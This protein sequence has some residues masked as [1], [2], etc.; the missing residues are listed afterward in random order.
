MTTSQ[1]ALISEVRVTSTSLYM[2]LKDG[3]V[4]GRSL[5]QVPFL[6]VAT[7]AQRENWQLINHGE[8]VRWPELNQEVSADQL[9]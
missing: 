6:L 1:P 9:F 7:A 2:T 4:L 8:S 5:V 3:R